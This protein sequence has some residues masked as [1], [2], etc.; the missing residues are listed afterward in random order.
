[1]NT[2]LLLMLD[3]TLV[4]MAGAIAKGTREVITP[5]LTSQLT[6]IVVFLPLVIANLGGTE[7]KP[8]MTTIAFTIT[9]AIVSA[10]LAAFVFVPVLY[11]LFEDFNSWR[12]NRKKNKEDLVQVG[13]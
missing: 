8:I 12:R 5:V 10:T 7:Y 3:L 4:L 9:A 2:K 6:I 13:F 11:S 1:M